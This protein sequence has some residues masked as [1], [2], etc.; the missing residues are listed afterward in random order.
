MWGN[1]GFVIGIRIGIGNRFRT[2]MMR[3][4]FGML[5]VIVLYCNFERIWG[6]ERGGRDLCIEVGCYK[7]LE[8]L[9][10]RGSSEALKYSVVG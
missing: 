3:G 1:F 8:A 7:G 6:R 4:C 2:E 9:E 10:G 5:E